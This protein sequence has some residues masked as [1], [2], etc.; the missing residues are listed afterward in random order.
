MHSRQQ[1][2]KCKFINYKMLLEKTKK[3]AERNWLLISQKKI[4]LRMIKQ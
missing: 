1:N 4:L 3:E 2:P